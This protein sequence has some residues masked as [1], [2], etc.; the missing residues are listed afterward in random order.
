MIVSARSQHGSTPPSHSVSRDAAETA[1]EL[2]LTVGRVDARG[3]W[4]ASHAN[5][6]G[7]HVGMDI[8]CVTLAEQIERLA[9]WSQH[10]FYATCHVIALALLASTPDTFQVLPEHM[11]AQ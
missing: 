1:V 10:D 6:L 5:A 8:L 4:I 11:V 7:G 2:A 3:V 9:D